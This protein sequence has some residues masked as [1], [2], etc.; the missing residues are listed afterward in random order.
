MYSTAVEK[1]DSI[2]I[3]RETTV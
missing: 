2:I 3:S 1:K